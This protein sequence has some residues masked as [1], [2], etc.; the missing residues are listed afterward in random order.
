MHPITKY[1]IRKRFKIFVSL[2]IGYILRMF[3]ILRSLRNIVYFVY[4]TCNKS[5]YDTPRKKTSL[6]ESLA[7][8]PIRDSRETLDEREKS[9]RDSR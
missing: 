3:V 4:N 5:R 6:G 9:C 7:Y 1:K 2:V 8:N